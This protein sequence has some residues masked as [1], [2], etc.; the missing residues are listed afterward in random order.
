MSEDLTNKTV[1]WVNEIVSYAA[2]LPSRRVREEYLA[3]RRRELVA[4]AQAEGGAARDAA[5][6]ADACVN[7]TRR[8]TTELLAQRVG[9]PQGRA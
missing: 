5:I 3:E 6:L 7:A 1:A 8:I 4:G 9:A 2:Q